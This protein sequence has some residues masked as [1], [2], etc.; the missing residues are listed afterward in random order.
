[1]T[2]IHSKVARRRLGADELK[3]RIVWGTGLMLW[4][5]GVLAGFG[6]LLVH[7]TTAS[8]EPSSDVG[9]FCNLREYPDS[10][11]VGT[12]HPKPGNIEVVMALHPQCPCSLNSLNELGRLLATTPETS[13]CTL[14]VYAPEDA[15]EDWFDTANMRVAEK[16]AGLQVVRDVQAEHASLLG[17]SASGACVVIGDSGEILFRGG[18]TAGRSCAAESP[19]SRTVASILRGEPSVFITTPVFGC[20]FSN[21]VP[22]S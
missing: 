17:L 14:L 12:L 16:I 2:N 3:H 20:K 21:T 9:L 8:S 5:V 22:Q 1:M 15:S 10:E 4:F 7:D 13:H 19:G 6:I 18:V 11:F